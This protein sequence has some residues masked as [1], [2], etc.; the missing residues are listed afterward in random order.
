MDISRNNPEN[1]VTT[2]RTD[3]ALL[4][5]EKRPHQK[6]KGRAEMW[7]GTEMIQPPSQT[8]PGKKGHSRPG[9]GAEETPH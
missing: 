9:K 7:L 4:N 1:T 5:I 2:G 3:F 8:V 6:E